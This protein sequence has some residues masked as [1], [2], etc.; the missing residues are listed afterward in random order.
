MSGHTT[1]ITQH[2]K[3][4]RRKW[5]TGQVRTSLARKDG[6]GECLIKKISTLVVD[7][8]HWVTATKLQSTLGLHTD[9]TYLAACQY[10]YS[11]PQYHW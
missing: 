1:G 10:G 4:V 11:P 3:W 2:K 8:N 5:V 7:V 6:T 9:N